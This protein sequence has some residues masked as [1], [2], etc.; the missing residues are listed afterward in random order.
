VAQAIWLKKDIG[1]DYNGNTS[2]TV[3]DQ[4]GYDPPYPQYVVKFE[5]PAP[6]PILFAVEIRDSALLPSNIVDLVKAS[7]YATFTGADGRGRVKIGSELLASKFYPGIIAIGPTVSVLSVL[8]GTSVAD[9]T[10]VLV[11][12]DQVPTLD[13]DDIT[14]TLV[15]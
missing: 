8:I 4:D 2:V 11:G 10:S 12:I 14:V 9:Q 3:E 15:P 13:L 5:R 7:I 6:L 1:C